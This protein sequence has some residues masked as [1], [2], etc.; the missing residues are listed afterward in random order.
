MYNEYYE[1]FRINLKPLVA[2]TGKSISSLAAEIGITT[3]TLSRYLSGARKP[4]LP[5]VFKIVDY[6]HVSLD[7]LFG[8]RDNENIRF[9]DD[10]YEIMQLY[11]I[12]ADNDKEVVRAVL[13]RYDKD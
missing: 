12:A 8:N 7:W 1:N 11:S 5:I 10:I 2:A 3:S 13:K 6:F 4:E 9:E